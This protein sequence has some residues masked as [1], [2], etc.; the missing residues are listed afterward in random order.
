MFIHFQLLPFNIQVLNGHKFWLTFY[1]FSFALV[2]FK[3]LGLRNY[4]QRWVFA[5]QPTQHGY[6]SIV[7]F[8]YNCKMCAKIPQ[9]VSHELKIW[10]TFKKIFFL[11]LSLHNIVGTSTIWTQPRNQEQFASLFLAEPTLST[12]IN[13]VMNEVPVCWARLLLLCYRDQNVVGGNWS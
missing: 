9:S 4:R 1:F 3:V 8:L 10:K 5:K 11:S 12:C 13:W 2:F 6:K 7:K